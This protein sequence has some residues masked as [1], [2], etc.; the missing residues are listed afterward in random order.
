MSSSED[1]DSSASPRPSEEGA[2][3]GAAAPPV[4]M[5]GGPSS[6]TPH[7][8]N[9][10]TAQ[11]AS[12][13]R[14]RPRRKAP[15]VDYQGMDFYA[16]ISESSDEW[17]A[18][19]EE[20][21][22][23]S[24]SQSEDAGEVVEEEEDLCARK[25]SHGEAGPS[26]RHGGERRRG[27]GRGVRL[28]PAVR[29]SQPSLGLNDLSAG[30]EHKDDQLITGDEEDEGSG[31]D[32]R[33]PLHR[34]LLD[35]L[36]AR[37]R[38]PQAQKK[39]QPQPH[40]DAVQPPR[41]RK[42]PPKGFQRAA[43]GEGAQ[44]E[45]EG[46]GVGR[47]V[48]R[49]A[50]EADSDAE[51]RDHDPPLQG[52]SH[53]GDGRQ[54]SVGQ[55]ASEP[56]EGGCAAAPT[57]ALPHGIA[58]QKRGQRRTTSRIRTALRRALWLLFGVPEEGNLRAAVSELGTSGRAVDLEAMA[59]LILR[60]EQDPEAAKVAVAD[61]GLEF[62]GY[63]RRRR[64]SAGAARD[65]GTD[66]SGADVEGSTVAKPPRGRGRARGRGRL[67]GR[68]AVGVGEGEES[69]EGRGRKGGRP[70]GSMAETYSLRGG[71]ARASA[72]GPGSMDDA[73]MEDPPGLMDEEQLVA[74]PAPQLP[75]RTYKG[76][77]FKALLA[78]QQQQQAGS[79]KHGWM[80]C[81]E[82]PGLAYHYGAEGLAVQQGPNGTSLLLP[83][84]EARGAAAAAAEAQN[85]ASA[86]AAEAA[87]IGLEIRM[88]R[89][90][91][92]KGE[93][94]HA[95]APAAAASAARAAADTAAQRAAAAAASAAAWAAQIG[96]GAISVGGQGGA[97]GRR[98]AG[99]SS[100]KAKGQAGSGLY[101]FRAFTGLTLPQMAYYASL[102]QQPQL[103]LL[104]PYEPGSYS[105]QKGDFA[106]SL[107]DVDVLGEGAGLPPPPE[108]QHPSLAS[109][110]FHSLITSS[111]CAPAVAAAAAQ[112]AGRPPASGNAGLG[113]IQ[114][115]Q[116]QHQQQHQPLPSCF[117]SLRMRFN[118]GC[119]MPVWVPTQ[120]Y[121]LGARA[122][123]TSTA[124]KR[125]QVREEGV[126]GEQQDVDASNDQQQQQQ[127]QQ[128]QRQQPQALW[129]GKGGKLN[130]DHPPHVV[131]LTPLQARCLPPHPG[132]GSTPAL[133]P[134]K[135]AA[136]SRKRSR[137]GSIRHL[138]EANGAGQEDPI[139]TSSEHIEIRGSSSSWGVSGRGA[140][141]VGSL[142]HGNSF[143][144]LWEARVPSY[145]LLPNTAA[146]SPNFPAPSPHTP[147]P[148]RS[149]PAP[150][151]G[152]TGQVTIARGL[153]SPDDAA[154]AV[155]LVVLA[156]QPYST[157]LAEQLAVLHGSLSARSCQNVCHGGM[158]ADLAKRELRE[159]AAGTV[160]CSTGSR[161]QL[162]C[163]R[164]ATLQGDQAFLKNASS[165]CQ[166]RF[167]DFLEF[168]QQQHTEPRL[169]PLNFE[170][171]EY[172]AK[173][174]RPR[175][176]EE[177]QHFLA[178]LR[179]CPS[180]ASGKPHLPAPLQL[181]PA[182]L[183]PAAGPMA[184]PKVGCGGCEVCRDPAR[185][186]EPCV[187]SGLL[188]GGLQWG[189]YPAARALARKIAAQQSQQELTDPVP[190]IVDHDL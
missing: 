73:H 66:T 179:A 72:E 136:A 150:L 125:V 123:Q 70:R 48:D 118:V 88:Q 164:M 157:D 146:A 148:A 152:L 1:D 74:A 149:Q 133:P 187:W 153:G 90:R 78:R 21:P 120:I 59:A 134:K 46:E 114:G 13:A 117:I 4:A 162:G 155:D 119:I 8:Q 185:L 137:V 31:G 181:H 106:R 52:W 145:L 55:G 61:A 63:K 44:C 127:E 97:N 111:I 64:R 91:T 139:G 93:E 80:P 47:N 102:V 142:P 45:T 169:P 140:S 168:K 159:Q 3:G 25:G 165:A 131:A 138:Q 16:D 183:H 113:A 124:P 163:C 110:T 38:Q 170:L 68:R 147:F 14:S 86:A 105:S 51:P 108:Q 28:S 50:R 135:A 24:S 141:V 122:T 174:R 85:E 71:R 20:Q 27:R 144:L 186:A 58:S 30:A 83:T 62:Y 98:R 87:R 171:E 67:Q 77:E 7:P 19:Q 12:N 184:L 42:R 160:L 166:R 121:A 10:A 79:S 26:G 172:G 36:A 189:A 116:R 129:V 75:N 109:T 84:W 65:G 130:S 177:L 32:F 2:G 100:H 107:L 101:G 176:G 81:Q 40:S 132:P 39:R 173:A 190:A 94:N 53:E 17:Q 35:M 158:E 178:L 29:R 49:G 128:Q 95:Q 33:H 126:Q 76:P 156:L 151:A 56:E 22:G 82:H 6:A 104:K 89:G 5:L 143:D 115:Q 99:A 182:T 92:K 69:F 43:G 37:R 41:K 11:P 154:R 60:V 112:P 57:S 103:V 15:R 167:L 9:Q 180:A 188:T 96:G 54:G 34:Q 175:R 18:G 161:Q 23:S